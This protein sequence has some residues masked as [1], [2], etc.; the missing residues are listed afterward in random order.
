MRVLLLILYRYARRKRRAGIK[1]LFEE[2]SVC[3]SDVC[4]L[5]WRNCERCVVFIL[6]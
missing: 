4:R 1:M 2:T 6:L 3:V 5:L